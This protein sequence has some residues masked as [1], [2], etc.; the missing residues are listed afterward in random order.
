MTELDPGILRPW[1]DE[2]EAYVASIRPDDPRHPIANAMRGI[3]A[4]A[5]QS[6]RP[7]ADSTANFVDNKE[8]IQQL[9]TLRQQAE[10]A[11]APR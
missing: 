7:S 3:I 6:L 10:D 11:L 2:Y 8:I 1:L 4:A 9:A 5:R